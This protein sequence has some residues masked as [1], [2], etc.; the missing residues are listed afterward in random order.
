VAVWPLGAVVLLL[1]R[2]LAGEWL[3][4]FAWYVPVNLAV[5]ALLGLT[6]WQGGLS[7]DDLGLARRRTRAGLLLGAVVA[8]V[9]AV[10]IVAGAVLPWTSSLFEDQRIA[11]VDGLGELAYQALVRVPLG[12]V[13]LEE[14]A[15]RGLLLGFAARWWSTRSAIAFSSALFGLWHIHPTLDALNANDLAGGWPARSGAVVAGVA[16][17][18]VAGVWF[19]FLR[20]AS[21]SLI[22]P[23]LAHAATNGV[24][25]VTAYVVLQSG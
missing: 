4:P 24:A 10:I 19:C 16:F 23:A 20:Q 1:G 18:A 7:L 3:I 12:T 15:F 11:D 22:A 25:T 6:A 13:V 21:G 5:T 2:N 17:T 8:A 14:F 9:S